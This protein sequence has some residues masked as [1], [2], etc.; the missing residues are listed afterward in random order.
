MLCE[1]TVKHQCGAQFWHAHVKLLTWRLDFSNLG[2]SAADVSNRMLEISS[3][4][5][6]LHLA[7]SRNP[8]EHFG[9]LCSLVILVQ[10]W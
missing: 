2:F 9:P 4:L 3:L 6:C 10:H 1:E 8:I 5:A 7:L